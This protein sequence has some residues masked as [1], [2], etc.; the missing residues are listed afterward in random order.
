MAPEA[1]AS[2]VKAEL[3]ARCCIALCCWLAIGCNRSASDITVT[4]TIEPTPPVTGVATVVRLTL[5]DQ[6]RKPISGA[7]LHLDAHMSHPGMAP[8]TADVIERGNGAYEARLFLSMT[9]AWV[10]VVTG[11]LSDG[12]RINQTFSPP[13][14][15]KEDKRA[16]NKI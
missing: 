13:L 6:D 11:E 5:H 8:V 12:R 2:G 9:G 16:R 15:S 1:L 14:S 4:W 10:F 7:R 3:A